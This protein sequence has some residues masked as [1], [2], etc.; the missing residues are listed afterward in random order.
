MQISPDFQKPR[1]D[2]KHAWRLDFPRQLRSG[3]PNRLH[4]EP[5]DA[6]LIFIFTDWRQLGHYNILR[7]YPTACLP[8]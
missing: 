4:I 2:N 7:S 5:H 6:E 3:G 1:M 8:W